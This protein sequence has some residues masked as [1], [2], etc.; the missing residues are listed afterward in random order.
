[1]VLLRRAH[2]ALAVAAGAMLLGACAPGSADPTPTVTPS[3][4]PEVTVAPTPEVD[5]VTPTDLE[6]FPTGPSV[7]TTPLPTE[8]EALMPPAM[9]TEFDGIPLNADGMGGGIRADSSRVCVWGS[10]GAPRT[11]LVVVIGYAPQRAADDELYRLRTEEGYN[12]YNVSDGI[13][14][15]RS[16]QQDDLP[17]PAGRT[18]FY[19]DGVIIDTQYSG[20]GPVGFTS[21][22]VATVW[23]ATPLPSP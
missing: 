4:T 3:P 8:C 12:C 17:L 15:E 2:L 18:L 11:R 13:R 16:W 21:S 7:S 20:I 10:P 5:T 19:R 14:C 1:M 23:P 22:I 9:L 6:P